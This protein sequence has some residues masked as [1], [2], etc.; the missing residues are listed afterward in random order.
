MDGT[1]QLLSNGMIH[2]INVYISV[3]IG[4]SKSYDQCGVYFMS[5]LVDVTLGLLVTYYL[6]V[7]SNYVLS[8]SY[9]S[10]MKSGNYFKGIRRGT[11]VFYVIDCSAWAKQIGI[12]LV[13]VFLVDSIYSRL[14]Q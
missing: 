8:K 6:V 5:L 4:N 7:I 9:T 2:V 11:R 12:W 14:R 13:I 3:E 10:R 1:K